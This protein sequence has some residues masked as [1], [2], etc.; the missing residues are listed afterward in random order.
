MSRNYILFYSCDHIQ[1]VTH[2]CLESYK[3]VSIKYIPIHQE[4]NPSIVRSKEFMLLSV[5]SCYGFAVTQLK[6]I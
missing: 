5:V 4:I 3:K 1:Y 2:N 6:E